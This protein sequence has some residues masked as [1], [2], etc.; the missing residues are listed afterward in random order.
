VDD[1]LTTVRTRGL[2]FSEDDPRVPWSTLEQKFARE[3]EDVKLDPTPG[4]A[5]TASDPVRVYLR[6]MGASPLLTREGEVEIAK[7]LERGHLS[8]LKALSRLPLV[9][10]QVL[11]IGKI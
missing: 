10:H 3:A 1:L 4:V 2:N 7:R 6:E 5:E 11:S 9:I 8:T